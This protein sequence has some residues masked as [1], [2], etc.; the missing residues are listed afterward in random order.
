MPVNVGVQI[1]SQVCA[2]LDRA[3]NVNN[4]DTSASKFVHRAICPENILIDQDGRVVMLGVPEDLRGGSPADLAKVD[5]VFIPKKRIAYMA[6]EVFRGESVDWRADVFSA[7]MLLYELL[8]GA[9]IIN[10]GIVEF[11]MSFRS[12]VSRRSIEYPHTYGDF[13]FE[14]TCLG[15]TRT[16]VPRPVSPAARFLPSSKNEVVPKEMDE[17]V[18]RSLE[19]NPRHRFQTAQDMASVTRCLFTGASNPTRGNPW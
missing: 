9:P 4:S 18:I 5:P 10:I 7:G 13:G 1:V 8:T 14:S 2:A 12:P 16:R 11:V 15:I 6:P 17:I 3:H 19:L